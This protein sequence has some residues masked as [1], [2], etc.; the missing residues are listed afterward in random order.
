[1]RENARLVDPF[2]VAC[3]DCG[4]LAGQQCVNAVTDK[5]LRRALAH[6]HRLADARAAR[7]RERAS[8]GSA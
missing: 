3:R 1:M 8:R 4:A 5:P 2:V 6:P 7:D